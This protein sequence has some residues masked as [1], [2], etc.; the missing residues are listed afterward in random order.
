MT[1]F[2]FA[3]CFV[4]VPSLVPELLRDN[5]LVSCVFYP[6][7]KSLHA[8]V[9]VASNEPRGCLNCPETAGRYAQVIHDGR[10]V[11]GSG[12]QLERPS[13]NRRLFLV[14]NYAPPLARSLPAP[15][16]RALSQILKALAQGNSVTLVPN[17][18]MLATQ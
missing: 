9:Y 3:L 10:K 13:R 1:T 6:L 2:A 17:E 14:Y 8:P 16:V 15:A 12:V 11:T 5:R 18:A 7:A 4:A